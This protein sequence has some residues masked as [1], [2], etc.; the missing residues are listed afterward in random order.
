[1]L[2]GRNLQQIGEYG[3]IKKIYF[4]DRFAMKSVS[5]NVNPNNLDTVKL[6]YL[7]DAVWAL[8]VRQHFLSPPKHISKYH[9]SADR[10]VTAEFQ[11]EYY[12]QLVKSGILSEVEQDISVRS[13][14]VQSIGLRSRFKG[15]ELQDQYRKATAFES[16]VSRLKGIMELALEDNEHDDIFKKAFPT[17]MGQW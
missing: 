14:D 12:D 4:R 5:K 11:A 6:A 2:I 17:V 16:L 10:H 8:H 13:L 1:M 3:T 9:L 7:G 15:E